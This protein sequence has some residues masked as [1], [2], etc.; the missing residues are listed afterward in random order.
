[1]LVAPGGAEPGLGPRR[2]VSRRSRPARRSQAVLDLSLDGLVAPGE[3][4]RE[5]HGSSG[6]R[7]RTRRRRSRRV[8]L[9]RSSSFEDRL[10]CAVL[11]EN[12][13]NAAAWAESG[14]AP[15]GHEHVLL[16]AVGTG[17]GPA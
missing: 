10:G 6:S 15:Q 13:A 9:V 16:I 7:R 4:G 1:M 8:D 2:R 14:S 12:D 5:Q 11:V 17:S 3:F